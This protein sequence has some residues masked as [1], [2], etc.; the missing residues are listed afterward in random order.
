MAPED[1]SLHIERMP[2]KEPDEPGY[3]D[4]FTDND[5]PRE[6]RIMKDDSSVRWPPGWTLEMAAEWR[7]QHNLE[8]PEAR[9]QRF[10]LV[11]KS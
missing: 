4:V 3:Q 9:R 11:E 7:R 6:P 2:R 1:E 5:I 8:S 10:K